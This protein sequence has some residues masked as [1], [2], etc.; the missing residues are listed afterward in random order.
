MHWR[1]WYAYVLDFEGCRTDDDVLEAI[2]FDRVVAM[3]G[4]R[5]LCGRRP[6]ELLDQFFGGHAAFR[7]AVDA[8]ADEDIVNHPGFQIREPMDVWLE[9]LARWAPRLDVAVGRGRTSTCARTTPQHLLRGAPC[10]VCRPG[11]S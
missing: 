3:A 10:H 6:G 7:A 4:V 11:A 2:A 9:G 1:R 8:V 5:D